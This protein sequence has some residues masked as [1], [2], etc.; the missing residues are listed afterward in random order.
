MDERRCFPNNTSLKK[1]LRLHQERTTLECDKCDSVF[2]SP[3]SLAI[4]IK[5]RH[6]EGYVCQCGAKFASPVQRYGTRSTVTRIDYHNFL[7]SVGFNMFGYCLVVLT[8]IT[9]FVN[10]ILIILG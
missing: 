4:H 1:H 3:V 10:C 9:S 7:E 8:G 5:R 6:G 2:K